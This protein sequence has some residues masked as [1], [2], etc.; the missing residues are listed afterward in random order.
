MNENIH[1]RMTD[2][3]ITDDER[4]FR[5][6]MM[7]SNVPPIKA[8]K[9][10]AKAVRRKLPGSA[11]I[12]SFGRHSQRLRWIMSSAAM[13]AIVLVCVALWPTHQ[14]AW[15]EVVKTLQDMPWIRL[16]GELKQDKMEVWMSLQR[17]VA[18]QR[19][20][21]L[22]RFDDYRT[23]V[24]YE[25]SAEEQ[26]I[27]R[28]PINDERAFNSISSVFAS[29]FRQ[30]DQVGDEFAGNRI[31]SQTRQSV[32]DSGKKWIDYELTL[33]TLPGVSSKVVIRVDPETNLPVSMRFQEDVDHAL[34]MKIDYPETGP[35]DIYAIGVPRDARV[36]D[37]MP[38]RN[39]KRIAEILDRNR[40]ELDNYVAAYGFVPN[41]PQALIYRSGDQWR[42]ASCSPTRDLFKSN[43]E[44]G[45]FLAE[46][47]P[48][49]E[50]ELRSWWKTRLSHYTI[51]ADMLCDGRTVYHASYENPASPVFEPFQ[52]VR[53]GD[54]HSIAQ[55]MGNAGNMPEFHVYP[56]LNSYVQIEMTLTKDPTDGPEGSILVT[57]SYL[58]EHQTSK[59]W[60]NPKLGYA[61]VQ[62]QHSLRQID[63][64]KPNVTPAEQQ[65]TYRFE[66]FKQSPRGIWYPTVIVRSNAIGSQQ[67]EAELS[68]GATATASDDRTYYHLDFTTELS[69]DL[70]KHTSG[71][72]FV[73]LDKNSTD[74]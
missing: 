65:Q 34:N 17:D 37:R 16:V 28:V 70:F 7:D 27:Y 54:G 74:E 62:A 56:D 63:E 36:V 60:L 18:A 51:V 1:N 12:D 14:Q 50:G 49:N 43:R 11:T 35:Q 41:S 9:K 72:V 19:S 44:Y 57:R 59:Y 55:T 5:T 26:L 42:T 47:P 52:S 67:T 22:S 2:S 20:K 6:L 64:N 61:A 33:Q 58:S 48:A 4:A 68:A 40:R 24:R 21:K 66:N 29:I 53:A 31:V 73:P 23:G 38:T 39:L 69:S 8:P 45:A 10:L 25:F 46:Q 32:Q 15:G 3:D 13:V 30:D 71:T